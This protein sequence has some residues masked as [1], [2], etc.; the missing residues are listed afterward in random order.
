ML[1]RKNDHG[2]NDHVSVVK[3]IAMLLL[4][5]G[6]TGVPALSHTF[7]MLRM[8]VFLMV[9]LLHN[10]L[11]HLGFYHSGTVLYNWRGMAE[12]LPHIA[13]MHVTDEMLGG[14]WFITELFFSTIIFVV[15]SPLISRCPLLWCAV[16]VGVA[17]LMETMGWHFRV[18]SATFL[19]A[20]FYT[21]GFWVRGRELSHNGWVIAA[22]AAAVWGVSL[23]LP[24]HLNHID[25]VTL[26][27]FFVVVALGGWLM[28]A[29]AWQVLTHCPKLTRVLCHIGNRT[30]IILTLHLTAMRALSWVLTH[31]G[32]LP[33]GHIAE[34]PPVYLF[35]LYML[36]GLAGPLLYDALAEN[37]KMVFRKH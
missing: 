11:W 15:L 18:R 31:C 21:L 19:S 7:S 32:V 14:Y 17:M 28:S 12:Q 3:A 36:V 23:V 9:V 22:L 27:V 35:P 5:Y 1:L 16:L 2:L 30:L 20:A 37:V 13:V 34:F 24:G 26:P 33:A 6:H 25:P 4:L 29:L 10:A 8:P